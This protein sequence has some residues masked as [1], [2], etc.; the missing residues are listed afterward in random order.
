[1]ILV[2]QKPIA[3]LFVLFSFCILV[4]SIFVRVSLQSDEDLQE[5][6]IT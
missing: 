1:M 4:Y 2:N 6:H 5:F 3:L